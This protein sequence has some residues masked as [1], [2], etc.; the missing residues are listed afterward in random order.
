MTAARAQAALERAR[1]SAVALAV[2]E[3]ELA[4]LDR[5]LGALRE[6]RGAL[7]R[8][9]E[10]GADPARGAHAREALVA[11]ADAEQAMRTTRMRLAAEAAAAGREFAARTRAYRALRRSP[12]PATPSS[13]V[14]NL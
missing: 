7:R 3:A 10:C 14:D 5:A 8:E 12:N 2:R 6:R 11:L 1:K 13:R 9:L 4:R